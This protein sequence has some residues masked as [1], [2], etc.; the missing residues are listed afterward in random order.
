MGVGAQIG[1]LTSADDT[2][3]AIT[4]LGNDLTVESDIKSE[5]NNWDAGV[6][7]IVD[8]YFDI[9][10][11][12]KSMRLSLTYYFGLTDILKDNTGSSWNNSIILLS[13]AIPIGGSS[14]KEADD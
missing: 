6:T 5:L 9:T 2:Y 10:N 11:K 7:G 8:Y 14:K 4:L 12:M 13:L 3:E 1:Y